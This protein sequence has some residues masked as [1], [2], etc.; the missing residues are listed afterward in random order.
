MLPCLCC[1][2]PH[3]TLFPAQDATVPG[4]PA[5]HS[6]EPAES[7]SGDRNDILCKVAIM[8]TSGGEGPRGK[9]VDICS[10]VGK[11]SLDPKF[12]DVTFVARDGLTV[13][14]NRAYLAA[15]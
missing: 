6:S 15:R 1:K 2:E 8:Y 7:C 3:T 10:A 11:L 12:Q 5:K 13:R 14:G 4:H 9:P